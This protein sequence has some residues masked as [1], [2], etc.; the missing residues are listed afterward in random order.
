MRQISMGIIGVVMLGM[1]AAPVWG[2]GALAPSGMAMTSCRVPDEARE[3]VITAEYASDAAYA[4]H[5]GFTTYYSAQIYDLGVFQPGDQRTFR[6]QLPSGVL[7]TALYTWE[8]I[9]DHWKQRIDVTFLNAVYD[10]ICSDDV[11]RMVATLPRL[12]APDGAGCDQF[13]PIDEQSHM[14]T[15]VSDAPFYWMPSPDG[16]TPYQAQ[17]G[18]TAW[19]I[20]QQNDFAVIVWACNVLFV[21]MEMVQ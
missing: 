1:L 13:M 21:P 4:G 7:A 5:F 3:F 8:Y 14:V 16:L 20:D 17:A 15:F 10:L 19:M 11:L 6:F 18:Q 2:Q 9:A 12:A